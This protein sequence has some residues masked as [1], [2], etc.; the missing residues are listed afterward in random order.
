MNLQHIE[1][2]SPSPAN[3]TKLS[4]SWRGTL[5][6]E[7]TLFTLGVAFSMF[8]DGIVLHQLLQWHHLASHTHPPRNLSDLQ[9]NTLLDGLFHAGA[10]VVAL[11]G[12]WML[13]HNAKRGAFLHA[14]RRLL[15][16]AFIAG[17]GA[18]NVVE[19]IINHFILQVHHV[20]ENVPNVWTY[21]V[22]FLALLGFA[23]LLIG[24]K[25]IKNARAEVR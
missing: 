8:F 19:N 21:D 2:A 23:P 14:P 16:G 20:R 12:V 3:D 7:R 6:A 15:F 24:I 18:F 1:S 25:M 5:G 11:W 22:V 4:R 9:F 10:W 17:W 13:I